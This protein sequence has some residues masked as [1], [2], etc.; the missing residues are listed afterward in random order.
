[1]KEKYQAAFI[2]PIGA[3]K[4]LGEDGWEFKSS[5]R[6]SK[7]LG[8]YLVELLDLE[9]LDAYS[10]IVR[11]AGDDIKMSIFLDDCNEVENIY[12]QFYD[13]SIKGFS[14]T[15]KVNGCFSEVEIFIPSKNLSPL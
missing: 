12:F 8:E 7:Q 6:L 9:F 4:V 5:K 10:G 15:C 11:Y 13:E 14:E 3:S 1:M 2:I